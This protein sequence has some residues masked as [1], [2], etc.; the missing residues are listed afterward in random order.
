MS[1]A[2]PISKLLSEIVGDDE[3]AFMTERLGYR[4]AMKGVR[5]IRL[6]IE[7]GEGHRRII[8][9]IAR[10]SGRG[11]ELE[12]AIAATREMRANEYE[13]AWL[14]KCRAEAATFRPF[15]CAIG[16]HSIPEGIW[17]L[18]CKWRP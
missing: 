13:V 10:V 12:R 11:D 6:W 16:S 2:Y 7:S 1:G 14:E 3:V 9:Q 8:G 18:R 15:L 4:D 5:R 17:H